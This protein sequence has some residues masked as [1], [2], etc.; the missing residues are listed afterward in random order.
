MFHMQSPNGEFI[1][2]LTLKVVAGKVTGDFDFGEGRKLNIENGTWD[3][4]T[5][6]MTV[7]RDRPQGGTVVYQMKA[8]LLGKQLKGSVETELDGEKRAGEWRA[9]RK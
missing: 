3:G 9:E 1:S 2:R 7:R 5:L 6:R 4:S 8:S